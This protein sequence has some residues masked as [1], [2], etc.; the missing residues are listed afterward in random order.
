MSYSRPSNILVL[1]YMDVEAMDLSPIT[2]PL[3]GNYLQLNS[4]R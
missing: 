2:L 1:A 3:K 4:T